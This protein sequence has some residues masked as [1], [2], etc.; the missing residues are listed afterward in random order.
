MLLLSVEL[1]FLSLPFVLS[2]LCLG[3]VRSPARLHLR[4]LK[5]SHL[6]SFRLLSAGVVVKKIT[7]SRHS[8]FNFHHS[9]SSVTVRPAPGSDR[10]SFFL[11]FFLTFS[12]RQ[13]HFPF[14]SRW[15]AFHSLSRPRLRTYCRRATAAPTFTSHPRIQ[16]RPTLAGGP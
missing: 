2:P 11:T 12:S 16:P 14:H 10:P 15:P 1:G 7:N 9:L 13:A 6:P 4:S 3:R 8:F 5:T